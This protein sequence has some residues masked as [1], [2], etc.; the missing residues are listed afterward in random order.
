MIKKF[1]AFLFIFALAMATYSMALAK[2]GSSSEI[3]NGYFSFTMP[4][5][6]EGTYIVKKQKNSIRIIE[7][8]SAKLKEGGFAFGLHIFKNPAEYADF[9]EYRKI[10]ELTDKK[11]VLYDVV[12]ER[13]VENTYADEEKAVED[14]LRLCDSANNIEIKGIKGSTYYTHQGLKGADLYKDV[15]KKYKQAIKEH[16]NYTRLKQENIGSISNLLLENKK[17]SMDKVGYA[18]QD[19]NSDGVDELFIGEISKSN[20]TIYNVYTISDRKPAY[21]TGVHYPEDKLFVCND[22]FLCKESHIAIDKDILVVLTLNR[23]SNK[24]KRQIE[25]M[26]NAMLSQANPW[27]MRFSLD[28]EYEKISEKEYKQGRH[29]FHN[30]KKFNYTPLSKVDNK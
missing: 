16:W 17:V 27:F 15:L 20:G 4:Q 6:T 1:I 30:Y 12:M 8:T 22:N 26:Y 3:S 29:V 2:N 18:F 23:N 13:P 25:Y 21:V 19:I 11:G 7:K 24:L 10:G 14:F 5:K 9:K 28:D